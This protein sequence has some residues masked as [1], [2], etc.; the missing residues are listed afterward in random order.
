MVEGIGKSDE[1][2]GYLQQLS[3]I[4]VNT[5]STLNNPTMDFTFHFACISFRSLWDLMAHI[6]YNI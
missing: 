1:R 5:K 2:S 3:Q 6:K 4:G